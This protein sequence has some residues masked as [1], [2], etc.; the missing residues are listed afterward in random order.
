[1]VL[2]ETTDLTETL[3]LPRQRRTSSRYNDGGAD[4]VFNTP[5]ELYHKDYYDAFDVVIA[6]LNRHFDLPAYSVMKEIESLLLQSFHGARVSFSDHFCKLYRDE[7]NFER[8]KLQLMMLPDL[9][10]TVNVGET[11]KICTVT[12]I[13][14]VIQLMN[15][16]SFSQSFLCE[17]NDL[18]RI[19]LTVPMSIVC[20]S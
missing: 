7:L 13:G 12:S 2:E 5:A 15:M 6:E 18:L 4:H 10:K 8:L 16:N 1:M 9:L 20:P 19:Y 17:V 11:I 3:K 14:T